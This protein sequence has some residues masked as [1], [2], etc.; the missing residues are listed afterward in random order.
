[1]SLDHPM[2]APN[3]YTAEPIPE[4]ARAEFSIR[5]SRSASW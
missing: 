5:L 3:T 4:A 2:A 1:M